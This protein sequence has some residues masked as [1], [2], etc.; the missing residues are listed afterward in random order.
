MGITNFAWEND[1]SGL[2]KSA[3]GAG[4][5]S[6]DMLKWGLL[7]LAKGKWQGEQLI[8]ASFV[9]RATSPISLSY[10]KSYYGFFW[11]VEDPEVEG[12]TWRCLEGRGAGG[13]F[14]FMYPELDLI[15]VITAHHKG[16]GKMLATAPNRIVPAFSK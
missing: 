6:R 15:A 4:L 13:Q 16:M 14:I 8:P 9:E 12:K 3:A 5:L 7:I 2:P 10:G 1:V 11:W